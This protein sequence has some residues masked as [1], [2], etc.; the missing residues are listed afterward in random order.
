MKTQVID[1]HVND[2]PIAMTTP[3]ISYFRFFS[4]KQAPRHSKKKDD[5]AEKYALRYKLKLLSVSHFDLGI[6]ASE[7]KDASVAELE[8]FLCAVNS[9]RIVVGTKLL[10][11]STESLSRAPVKSVVKLCQDIV[12]RGVT[13]VTL[14]DE[15]K[16][17]KSALDLDWIHLAV[18]ISLIEQERERRALRSQSAKEVFDKKLERGEI[19]S[20][21]GP[22]WLLRNKKSADSLKDGWDINQEKADIV[23]RIFK[24]ADAGNGQ[25]QIA[26]TLVSENIPTMEDANV[27]TSATVGAILQ[28]PAVY[29]LFTQKSGGLFQKEGYY[30]AII[31]KGLFS[32]TQ[33]AI[34]GRRDRGGIRKGVTT[35]FSGMSHCLLCGSTTRYVSTRN[36]GNAYIQCRAAYSDQ[37]LCDAKH[38]PYRAAEQAILDRLINK[39]RRDLSWPFIGDPSRQVSVLQDERDSLK[40]KQERLTE[41]AIFTPDVKIVAEQ[42]KAT[43]AQIKQLEKRIMD[44]EKSP[45]TTEEIYASEKLFT[46]HERLLLDGGGELEVLRRRMKVAIN[47]QLKRVEFLAFSG[48]TKYSTEIDAYLTLITEENREN[49]NS[50]FDTPLYRDRSATKHNDY[51]VSTRRTADIGK[52]ENFFNGKGVVVLSENPQFLIQVTYAGGSVRIIDATPFVSEDVLAKT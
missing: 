19:I 20:S 43:D 4:T 10:I 5:L 48:Q 47:R 45:L 21:R 40:H 30:P 39:Q 50:E 1:R 49:K 8:T 16:Y 42:L 27:W 12:D 31:S 23:R 7:N 13:I 25:V 24:L 51:K 32:S 14:D 3:A 29:G 22:A 37:S 44:V 18:A 9:G 41:L 28:N 46:Q 17:E 11:E 15:K 26:N 2:Q 36:A 52:F 34:E 38:F 33:A 6:S 35:L